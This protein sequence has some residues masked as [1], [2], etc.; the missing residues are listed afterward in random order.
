MRSSI[1]DSFLPLELTEKFIYNSGRQVPD[2][3][4]SAPRTDR[5]SPDSDGHP[6]GTASLDPKFVHSQPY[7]VAVT[8]ELPRTPSNLDAGNFMIDLTLLSL[9]SGTG[10]AAV[11]NTLSPIS[12]ARRPAILTYSSPLVD[13]ARRVVRLPF[14]VVGSRHEA[15]TLEVQMLEKVEFARGSRN[16]PQSLRL[17]I[18]SD[19]KMQFYSARVEFRARFTGLR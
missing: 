9:Q 5:N 19:G 17:E 15:E 14:Y 4:P 3:F 10:L 8:L 13:L 6:W 2:T 12:H 11:S 16:L 1:S 7:D 18:Q